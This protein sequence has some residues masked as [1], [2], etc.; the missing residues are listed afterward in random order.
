MYS[1]FATDESYG[2][3]HQNELTV[4]SK[5]D[6]KW[7]QSQTINQIVIMGYKTFESL[8]F[9][10]LDNRVNIVL[11]R[12]EMIRLNEDFVCNSGPFITSETY[13]VYID[14]FDRLFTILSYGRNLDKDVYVIGGIKTFCYLQKFITASYHS[15]FKIQSH[16]STFYMID[17]NEIEKKKVLLE[18]ELDDVKIT[19][20]GDALNSCGYI[21]EKLYFKNEY[22]DEEL[23]NFI[24][25]ATVE[26]V[27]EELLDVIQ[28]KIEEYVITDDPKMIASDFLKAYSLIDFVSDEIIKRLKRSIKFE[29]RIA[30]YK[31]AYDVDL[32][33]SFVKRSINVFKLTLRKT[34]F[35]LLEDHLKTNRSDEQ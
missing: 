15:I 6:M 3:S 14:D 26:K 21:I 8:N 24:N 10:P 30:T 19:G 33:I 4:R 35:E 12:D 20:N 13:F 17:E 1:I 27:N 18:T 32:T 34:Y 22:I 7:F 9:T 5:T 16:P 31:E 2:F 11:C 28:R 25:T 23:K 29:D